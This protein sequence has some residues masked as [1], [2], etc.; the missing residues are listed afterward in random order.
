MQNQSDMTD[1]WTHANLAAFAREDYAHA[2]RPGGVRRSPFWNKYAR[3]FMYP[4]AFDFSKGGPGTVKYRFTVFDAA[5]KTHVFDAPS[6]QSPLTPVWND[7]APG[8][9]WVYVSAVDKDGAVHGITYAGMSV[10]EVDWEA[11]RAAM[12]NYLQNSFLVINS[13]EEEEFGEFAS[14]DDF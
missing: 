4:P 2:I 5:G 13:T 14:F 6:S 10:Q 12:A 7:V 9:A 8:L 11:C 1:N 3:M